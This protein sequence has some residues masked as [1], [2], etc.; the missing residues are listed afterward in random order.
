MSKK[1]TTKS[2]SQPAA[3]AALKRAAKQALELARQTK[4]PAWVLEGDKLVDATKRPL[5]SASK[6]Q[7]RA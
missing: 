6:K 5:K 1:P 4:T 7:G 2:K 3:L